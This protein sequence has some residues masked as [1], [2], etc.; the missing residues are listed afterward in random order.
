MGVSNNVS[1]LEGKLRRLATTAE[2]SA[3]P[4]LE[5]AG[6]LFKARMRIAGQQAA[7]GDRRLSR[8]PRAGVL[9]ADWVI[10][11]RSPKL[12]A[13]S[14][15]RGP[16]GIRDNSYTFGKTKEHEI[17]PKRSKFL[18]FYWA[19]IGRVV[20]K[21]RVWHP[22]SRRENY[23]QRGAEDSRVLITRSLST[24]TKDMVKFAFDNPF[25]ARK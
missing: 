5:T 25:K 6:N 23:W 2:K 14:R 7:G 17:L 16:W 24:Q 20:Y 11:G 13:Y 1:E 21:K 8:L 12:R 22:G 4:Q 10:V 15:H 3:R 18:V 9:A 19:K